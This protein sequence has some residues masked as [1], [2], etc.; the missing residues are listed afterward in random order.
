M[1]DNR[2]RFRTEL[3][4]NTRTSCMNI[5]FLSIFTSGERE[6]GQTLY[7]SDVATYGVP[8][9]TTKHTNRQYD[10]H[11]LNMISPIGYDG[12]Q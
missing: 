1:V 2:N 10:S 9:N 11:Q 4:L 7:T 12:H 6:I 5:F 8:Q 3:Q